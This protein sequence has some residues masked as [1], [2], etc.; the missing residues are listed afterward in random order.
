MEHWITNLFFEERLCVSVLQPRK[1]TNNLSAGKQS[2][3]FLD[4]DDGKQM[5]HKRGGHME[6]WCGALD[7]CVCEADMR[8]KGGKREAV[9]DKEDLRKKRIE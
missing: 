3:S 8:Q 2:G 1:M 9:K 7:V 6:Q 4:K 5:L